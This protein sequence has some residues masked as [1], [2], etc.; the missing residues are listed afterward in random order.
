MTSLALTHPRLAG[1]K[2]A[3]AVDLHQHA[4]AGDAGSQVIA[5][6]GDQLPHKGG[7]GLV[8]GENGPV[9]AVRHL[10]ALR[11]GLQPPG[12]DKG[13]DIL[14][15]ELLKALAPLLRRQV[16]EE[17]VLHLAQ[18]L[19]ALGVKIVEKADEL[20]AGAVHIPDPDHL[21]FIVA[22]LPQDLQME[23]LHQLGQLDTVNAVGH[24]H[25]SLSSVK[26]V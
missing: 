11:E 20:E 7:G 14:G 25:R 13:G 12:D 15:Q 5:Q 22:S 21:I 19:K 10:S 18:H 23:F 2:D 26:S 3:L 6:A 4:V 16:G 1:D 8:G 24:G 17:G 9:I